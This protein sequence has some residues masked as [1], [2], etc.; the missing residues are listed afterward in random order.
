MDVGCELEISRMMEAFDQKGT[1]M[2]IR[3]IPKPQKDIDFNILAAFHYQHRVKTVTCESMEAVSR[4]LS[5]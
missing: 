1:S 3:V 5:S 4:L 2:V